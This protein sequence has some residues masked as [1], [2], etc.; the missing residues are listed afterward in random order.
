[1]V[2]TF[3]GQQTL[4]T[5]TFQAPQRSNA[6]MSVQEVDDGICATEREDEEEA[7]GL[8]ALAVYDSDSDEVSAPVVSVKIQGRA[9]ENHRYK[10]KDYWNGRF[11]EE[12]SFEWLVGFRDVQRQLTP[13]LNPTDRILIV[14]CGNSSFSADVYDAGFTNIVNIDFSAVVIEKMKSIH[15]E[16]RPHMEWRVMDMTDLTFCDG[17]FDVVLDKAAMDALVVSEGDVWNPHPDVVTSV[18]KMCKEVSRVLKPVN[19]KFLLISFNQPHF[20]TKYLMGY[21]AEEREV[22]AFQSHSGFS[23]RYNWNLDFEPIELQDQGVL[24]TFLYTMRR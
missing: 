22:D 12:D 13:L 7:F 8:G 15:G 17:E 3:V 19:A 20:R 6:H 4:R 21:R 1:M 9:K 24:E 5:L 10:E 16:V 23:D 11:V 18:D 2:D 14:G